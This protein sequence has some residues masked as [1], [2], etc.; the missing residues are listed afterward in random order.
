MTGLYNVLFSY[1]HKMAINLVNDLQKTWVRKCICG[2]CSCPV[3]MNVALSIN[4]LC[5]KSVSVNFGLYQIK[6]YSSAT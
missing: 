5:E 1:S 6:V 3:I 4:N 2:F